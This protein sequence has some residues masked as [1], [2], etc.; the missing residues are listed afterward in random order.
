MYFGM[1]G[2]VFD[3]TKKLTFYS[4]LFPLNCFRCGVKMLSFYQYQ[5]DV[6]PDYEQQL[7][8]KSTPF[9]ILV[10]LI[11]KFRIYIVQL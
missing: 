3:H 5:T 9:K 4:I 8:D 10:A 11:N 1:L 2:S 7:S 6:A